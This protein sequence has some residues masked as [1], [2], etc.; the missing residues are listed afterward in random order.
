MKRILILED[1]LALG[2]QWREVLEEAG[3]EVVHVLSGEEAI[4]VLDAGGVD[5]FI[6][7]MLIRGVDSQV[8]LRGG[9]SVL[10]HINLNIRPRPRLIAISGA[11]PSLNVLKH[12][13]SLRADS[14]FVKPIEPQEIVDAVDSLPEPDPEFEDS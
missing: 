12:A 6:S 8:G 4:G 14:T 7:D 1:D 3:H 11:H 2:S 9:L 13:Q 5:I 10:S